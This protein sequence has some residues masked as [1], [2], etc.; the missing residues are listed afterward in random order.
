MPRLA[1]DRPALPAPDLATTRHLTESDRRACR[2][3]ANHSCTTWSAPSAAPT[4]AWS[5]ND[6]QIGTSDVLSGEACGTSVGAQGVLHADV[7][8]LHTAEL[9]ANG[10]RPE[11]IATIIEGSTTRFTYA[12]RGAVASA[13]HP[14]ELVRIDRVR[15]VEAGR[16]T[17]SLE[18]QSLGPRAVALELSMR[19]AYDLAP[20]E[21]IKTGTADDSLAFQQGESLC[22][23]DSDLAVQLTCDGAAIAVS[24]DRRRAEVCW[25]LALTPGR[26][27][28]CVWSIAISD[29]TGVVVAGEGGELDVGS[30]SG[31]LS[32]GDHRLES[33]LE[34]SLRDLNAL[35]MG[36]REHPDEIFYAAGAPWYL[37]LFGRDS[38]WTARMLLSVDPR[39]AIGA[40]RTLARLAGTVTDHDNAEEPGKILHELRRG[41]FAFGATSLPPLY[42]GTI[43]ATPLWI[44]LLHDLW[45]TG[46]QDDVVRELLAPL[47]AALG[48]IVTCGDADG[49]G[50]LEYV[51]VSGHGLAN[52]GWK[53]SED[54]VRFADGRIAVGSVALCEVQGYAYEA[55]VGGS[56]L[57]EAFGRP[58]AERYRS[59]AAV[60]AERFRA[61]FWC[62][63]GAARYPALALDGRKQ[64]V[65]SLTSNIGHLLGTGL[66]NPD[67]EVLVADRIAGSDLDS[68]ARAADDVGERR[69]IQPAQLSLRIGLAARHR[70]RDRRPAPSRPR[71]AWRRV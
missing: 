6:G 47:E 11:H 48:W 58:G 2:N 69:R 14:D 52:Q 32:N 3:R 60:L 17:E 26:S 18:V 35:R 9:L 57:L 7:R 23:G 5:A 30:L 36:T 54:S 33:W 27:E 59:W 68:G 50:F 70:H 38:L 10:R 19:L 31:V 43:D 61:E 71:H 12:Y 62:G 22:W 29:Q 66:L 41:A 13:G 46:G 24:A 21:R 64:R 63:S 49:D 44:C 53:D 37:T 34:Q 39:P 45:L 16:L 1:V 20:V 67:E 65:D 56:D 51:D 42:Y 55:L 28:S 8:V 4:Q 15:R 40:L 25:P